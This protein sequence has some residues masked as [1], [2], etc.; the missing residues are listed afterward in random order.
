MK[1]AAAQQREFA[2]RAIMRVLRGATQC[3]CRAKERKRAAAG[4][5]RPTIPPNAR[6]GCD[7]RV[8]PPTSTEQRAHGPTLPKTAVMCTS[9]NRRDTANSVSTL[10]LGSW[11][12]PPT[13]KLANGPAA[14][15]K[16]RDRGDPA[17][18]PDRPRACSL[19]PERRFRRPGAQT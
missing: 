13:A 17:F 9:Y 3:D 10:D 14:R 5:T 16:K 6:V 8:V 19:A 11:E 4:F 1:C 18:W 7:F 2:S 15:N 12:I